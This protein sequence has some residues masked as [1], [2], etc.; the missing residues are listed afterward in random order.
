[1]KKLVALLASLAVAGSCLA[2]PALAAT[3]AVS[4]D[5]NLQPT[6]FS[7]LFGS[8]KAETPAGL[9]RFGGVEVLMP[10]DSFNM[11]LSSNMTMTFSEVTGLVGTI[12]A[13]QERPDAP[14]TQAYFDGI[15]EYFASN[16]ADMLVDQLYTTE[17]D[18]VTVY[19][20]ACDLSQ[21]YD[22][23]VGYMVFV[24]YGTEYTFVQLMLP[25]AADQFAFDSLNGALD[26]IA[27]CTETP[28]IEEIPELGQAVEVGGLMIRLP[29]DMQGVAD[30]DGSIMWTK[31]DADLIFGAIPNVTPD[32]AACTKADFDMAAN[33]LAF[34]LG[35]SVLGSQ[36]LRPA[37]S[38]D[39]AYLYAISYEDSGQL[40]LGGLGFFGV[41]DG[42][43]T[44]V[45]GF[46]SLDD[47]DA[48]S[49]VF[50]AVFG[51]ITLL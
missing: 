44:A 24:D 36:V 45:M 10:S 25:A 22:P 38:G 8:K 33:S 48:L 39:P 50:E 17:L 18:D 4:A 16:N 1:M 12:V 43:A 6:S 26:S 41:S 27:V 34:E 35:G 49:G 42:S 19:A 29:A 7:S 5:E 31:E 30:E 9:L 40:I 2:A 15:M 23:T 13:H 11:P 3:D 21:S 47:A 37:S 46:C 28:V 20:Y 32:V 14:D 51:N